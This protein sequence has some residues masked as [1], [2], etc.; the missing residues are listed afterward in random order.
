MPATVRVAAV[1]L[2][3]SSGRVMVGVVGPGRLELHEV[4]RFPNGPVTA[5]DGTLR[6]PLGRLLDEVLA[7]LSA[8]GPVDSVGVD[9]WAVDYG[10]L[11]A[12]GRLLDDPFCYRDPRGER[13]VERVDAVIDR[14]AR[15]TLTGTQHLPFNT[16]FQLAADT[17]LDDAA[18]LLLIPDLIA[19][20][21][22]GA[23][24]AEV[25]N[26]STTALYDPVR[27]TWA[28]GLAQDVG[29]PADI[30]PPVRQPGESVGSLLPEVC[31]RSGSRPGTPVLL[32]GSHDTASA[33]VAAPMASECSAYVSAGTWSLVGLELDTPVL[34][35][36]ARAANFTNELGVDSTVR[37][38]RNVAGLWVLSQAMQVW[39]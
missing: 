13:G 21:L 27:R 25:T 20:R 34:T 32:V 8:A 15:Y 38:L 11:D 31:E 36:A 18:T 19:W 24:G 22:S 14:V 28:T 23:V 7:G 26:A 6:W 1:D 33:V 10:L 29:I 12:S 39:G 35:E 3:A 4:H 9:T 37:F 17:R 5:S 30:L 16:L 2:G